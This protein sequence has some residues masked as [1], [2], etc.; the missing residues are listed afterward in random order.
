MLALILDFSQSPAP[1][2]LAINNDD[3]DDSRNAK[4][5]TL[6]PYP[7]EMSVK[8]KSSIKPSSANCN[9]PRPHKEGGKKVEAKFTNRERGRRSREIPCDKFA[10][11]IGIILIHIHKR[12]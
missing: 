6:N 3:G 8:R 4:A 2:L 9:F 10:P 1:A 12:G 7:T 11:G 5:G